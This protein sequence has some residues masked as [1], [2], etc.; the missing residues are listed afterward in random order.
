MKKI[1]LII[2]SNCV[3]F[4]NFD[5]NKN[6]YYYELF[7]FFDNIHNNKSIDIRFFDYFITYQR[8]YKIETID[9]SDKEY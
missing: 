1:Y 6:F 9:K 3:M 8:Q 2:Y 7:R 4:G 5:E